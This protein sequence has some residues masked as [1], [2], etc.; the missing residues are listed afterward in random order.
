MPIKNTTTNTVNEHEVNIYWNKVL[1]WK[2]LQLSESS[3][4]NKQN[5]TSIAGFNSP[6]LMRKQCVIFV[7]Y[8]ISVLFSLLRIEYTFIKIRSTV[9]GT[10][11]W[12]SFN[13]LFRSLCCWF[14]SRPTA[15][16]FKYTNS[17]RYNN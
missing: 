1:N 6:Q 8:I 13:T 9:M 3:A 7:N 11:L 16:Q 2:K 17:D 14:S 10:L 15:I 5:C 4:K 12:L